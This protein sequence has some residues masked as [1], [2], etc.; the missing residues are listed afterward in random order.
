MPV[1]LGGCAAN[2][3]VD[4]VRH[5]IAV[6]VCGC[7]GNDDDGDVVLRRLEAAG[8]GCGAIGRVRSH[9]T[10]KTVILLVKGQDRRFLHSFGANAAFEAAQ[11]SREWIDGLKVFYVGGLL[12]M[13]GIRMVELA[14]LLAYCRQRGIV[15]VVDVV[16]PHDY[17][18][19]EELRPLLPQVDYFLPN[20]DEAWRLTGQNETDGQIEAMLAAG[21]RTVIITRG[22]H[23]SIAAAGRDRWEAGAY[24]IEAIDPSGSGDAFDAGVIAGVLRGWD[25]ART[26]RFAAAMGASATTAVGTTDGVFGPEEASAF[27]GRHA[28]EVRQY[29]VGQ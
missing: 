26:L 11:I 13:P 5:G 2:V 27:L 12:A 16:V 14:E 7:V 10:S 23:G 15:T 20:D 28:L 25:M 29:T 22:P 4:L 9:P 24:Q 19:L 8:I 21:A 3:A 17:E 6:D 1:K 18:G